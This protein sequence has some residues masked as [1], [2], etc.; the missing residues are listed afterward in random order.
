[1]SKVKF[2]IDINM[3]INPIDFLYINFHFCKS[4]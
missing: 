1:M 2:C 3:N 4:R